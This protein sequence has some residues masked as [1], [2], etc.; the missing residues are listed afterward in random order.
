M[1]KRYVLKNRKRFCFFLAFVFT[2]VLT[3]FSV[4]SAYGSKGQ[5]YRTIVVRSGDTLWSIAERYN[6]DGDIRR[7]IHEIKK[8][9]NLKSSMIIQ[10]TDLK[11]IVD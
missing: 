5:T 7:Y 9:N 10:G 8:L 1:R 2:T 6:K 4:S 11:V 3:V